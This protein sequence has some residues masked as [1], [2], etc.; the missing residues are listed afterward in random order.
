M[1]D[2]IANNKRLAKNTALL[3]VRMAIL[4]LVTLYT[5]RVVLNALGVEDYGIYNVVAGLVSMFG[6]LTGSITVAISRFITFELGKK[7]NQ[8]LNKVFSSSVNVQFVIIVVIL[9]ISETIG[10]WF[11]N[12]K[13]V[14]PYE[15]LTAANYVY[16]ATIL[17]FA[18]T[19]FNVPYNAAIIAHEKMSAFAYISILEAVLKLL[20]AFV[21]EILNS[22]KLI[23]YG[24]LIMLVSVI[25]ILIYTIYC[26]R[27]FQE[28][29]YHYV[30]DKPI[31]IKMLSY[32]GWTYIGVSGAV[33]RDQGGIILINL[34]FGPLVNAARG[35]SVQVQHAVN[36]FSQNFMTAINPQITKSYA[37]GD[38][39][40]MKYLIS[41][42]TRFGYY[43]VLIISLPILFNTDYILHVWLK[44]VPDQSVWFVRLSI[45]FV[46]SESISN[47]LVTSASASG[48]IRNYQLLVGGIQFMNF[49]LSYLFL[50]WGCPAESVLVVAI[51]L[52]QCCLLSR[53]YILR[54]M[55]GLSSRHFLVHSYVPIFV[56]TFVSMIAPSFFLLFLDESLSSML[57]SSAIC[58]VSSLSSVYYLGLVEGERQ[59][60][61][62]KYDE[63]VN[64]YF[65]SKYDRY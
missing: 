35:I 43:L 16:Q 17:S 63:L 6:V 49:P 56:V 44:T 4:M 59:F 46:L 29:T 45:L 2:N 21:I 24:I 13:M 33:M 9:I 18:V 5:S 11:L 42:G 12:S 7:E 65:H 57:V 26:K 19:L 20:T 39:E 30:Y 60:F 34:F 54:G 52:S 61:R 25:L 32:A 15:R 55:I 48:K 62:C 40:H 47:P 37:S 53:L 10:V 27:I 41:K 14:I 23:A 22:D 8:E 31:L 36:N 38:V 3:Y 51:A 64:K 1:Q 58:L 28:C 50:L